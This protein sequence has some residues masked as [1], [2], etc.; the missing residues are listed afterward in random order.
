[1]DCDRATSVVTPELPPT[2][3]WARVASADDWD[4]P[5]L[6]FV[7]DTSYWATLAWTG[8]PAGVLASDPE[9]D[10]APFWEVPDGPTLL[11]RT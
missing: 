6:G 11:P 8:L 9:P 7:L 2:L 4:D 3:A 5:P 10:D 1:M